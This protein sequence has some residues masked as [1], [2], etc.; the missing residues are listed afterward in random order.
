MIRYI[1]GSKNSVDT[2]VHYVFE[3]MP[4][5]QECKSFCSADPNENRNI[6]VIN[7]GIV[8]ECYKGTPD[9]V[10]NALLETYGLHEQEHKLLV[11]RK[12]ERNVPLKMVRAVRIILSHLSR[13][14]YRKEVKEALKGGWNDR[15]KCLVK[16]LLKDIDFDSLNK[17]MS[18]EDIKKVIAFQVGQTISLMNEEELY[19]KDD[20]AEKYPTLECYLHRE[21]DTSVSEL[22]RK[23]KTMVSDML[24]YA[25]YEEDGDNVIFKRNYSKCKI[26]LKT[27]TIIDW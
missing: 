27:E 15:L 11:T 9:E 2:D 25:T 24:W 16:I 21:K 12:V 4:S 19:D 13:S 5:L 14:Q 3:E 22:D 7:D 20:I 1:H 18:A 23:M 6:I 10:N 17:N 26:N 8:T